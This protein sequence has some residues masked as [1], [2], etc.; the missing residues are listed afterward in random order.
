[1]WRNTADAYGLIQITLHW[2]I[3]ILIAVLLPLGLWMTGLDYYDPW[4]Q[5]APDLHRAI[6]ILLALLLILRMGWRLA[7]VQPRSLARSAW[8]KRSAVAAHRLDGEALPSPSSP[9][10]LSSSTSF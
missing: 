10:W 2:L 4:Y 6:G 9:P 8:E 7:Q 3:A 5:K 1:M